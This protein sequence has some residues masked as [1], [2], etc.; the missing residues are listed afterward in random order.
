MI[1]DTQEIILDN[2]KYTHVFDNTTGKQTILRYGE[3][4]RDETGDGFILA[5]AQEIE[6]LRAELSQA[7]GIIQECGIDYEDLQRGKLMKRKNA[8]HEGLYE[9]VQRTLFEGLETSLREARED[10]EKSKQ[11]LEDAEANM[12]SFLQESGLEEE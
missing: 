10:F 3:F 7:I 5:M 4:W 12:E 9:D 1:K 2:G 11:H 6:D 8:L